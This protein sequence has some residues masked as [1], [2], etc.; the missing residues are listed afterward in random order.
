MRIEHQR[1]TYTHK[2]VVHFGSP[3]SFAIM[4]RKENPTASWPGVK[5]DR[6]TT[7]FGF[8]ERAADGGPVVRPPGMVAIHQIGVHAKQLPSADWCADMGITGW[9]L[10][11]EQIKATADTVAA[12]PGTDAREGS[13]VQVLCH[14]SPGDL[15][16]R[17]ERDERKVDLTANR[18][19]EYIKMYRPK[20]F[21]PDGD[22]TVKVGLN[23]INHQ[24]LIPVDHPIVAVVTQIG[25][26]PQP[27]EG[28]QAV[29]ASVCSMFAQANIEAPAAAVESDSSES[30]C[31]CPLAVYHAA[32]GCFVAEYNQTVAPLIS[33]LDNVELQMHA[34]GVNGERISPLACLL[35]GCRRAKEV[36]GPL[37]NQATPSVPGNRSSVP[38]GEH[39]D[40]K[41]QAERCAMSNYLMHCS[42]PLGFVFE[43]S[44]TYTCC[45]R[46]DNNR[47]T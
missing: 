32:K 35:G 20:Y 4:A 42:R 22:T 43:I 31:T 6:F 38:V 13:S 8:V 29:G 40:A 36:G 15:N 44:C 24:V 28:G 25:T 19:C 18:V 7:P 34:I 16:G 2:S 21:G 41:V 27:M 5:Y 1:G 33:D 47:G 39:D 23:V 3:D 30:Y 10:V 14:F 12:Q 26:E 45:A 9:E 37:D 17:G 46:P 11:C